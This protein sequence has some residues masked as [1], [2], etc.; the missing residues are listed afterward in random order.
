M[1]E[2]SSIQSHA[3]NVEYDFTNTKLTSNAGIWFVEYLAK[4]SGL[5]GLL[6]G[7]NGTLKKRRRILSR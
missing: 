1:K 3:W 5:V 6:E 7:L 4:A 2:L